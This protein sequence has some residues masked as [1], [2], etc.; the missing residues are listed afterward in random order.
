MDIVRKT[1][2]DGYYTKEVEELVDKVTDE[3][4]SVINWDAITGGVP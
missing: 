1:I 4:N 3:I 2:R